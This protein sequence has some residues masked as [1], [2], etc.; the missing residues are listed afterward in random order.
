M[1]S[2]RRSL[3][4]LVLELLVRLP[5]RVGRDLGG[6]EGLDLLVLDGVAVLRE[7]PDLW[8]GVKFR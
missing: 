5:P 3:T 1:S 6:D 2:S 4:H 8:R 7:Q